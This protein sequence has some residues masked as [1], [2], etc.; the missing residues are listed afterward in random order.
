MCGLCVF[1]VL[2]VSIE[3]VLWPAALG[4]VVGVGWFVILASMCVRRARAAEDLAGPAQ[5]TWLCLLGIM[6]FTTACWHEQ[7]AA[8]VLA[9]PAIFL[10]VSRGSIRRTL[11]RAAAAT[12]ASGV[13]VGGYVVLFVL[14]VPSGRRGGANTIVAA[15]SVANRLVRL[16][17]MA[18]NLSLGTRARESTLDGLR[19][20]WEEVGRSLPGAA[21]CVLVV[22]AAIAFVSTLARDDGPHDR[23]DSGGDAS[24]RRGWLVLFGL[25][26]A[27]TSLAPIALVTW[28]PMHPRYLYGVGVGLAIAI[29]AVLDCCWKPTERSCWRRGLQ[30][31]MVG[32]IV[33]G[34]VL[35]ALSCVGWQAQFRARWRA[36]VDQ[37]EQLVRLVPAP[38]AGTV[39]V[40]IEISDGRLPGR[41]P[42]NPGV[43]GAMAQPWSCWAYVQHG[44][45]RS[46]VSA[47][48]ARSGQRLPIKAFAEGIRY[49]RG[50]CDAY[51]RADAGAKVVPWERVVA[52]A[53]D[54]RG[55]VRLVTR[56]EV[57]RRVGGGQGASE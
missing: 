4:S 9:L 24:L 19:D 54:D 56:E 44:Y 55:V 23:R 51:G 1:L 21:A 36:D 31:S 38:A 41:R 11:R 39:F 13:G 17:E 30:T 57:L 33:L 14:T 35:G 25:G 26:M 48:H 6:G 20:G 34:G 52:F 45:A 15:D 3:A 8:G 50:V 28:Q 49:P 42:S 40:P 16:C 43:Q 18:W 46:D 32:L 7:P 2:P 10:T 22:L 29:A 37:M 47:T 53:V 27:M 12:V 5:W